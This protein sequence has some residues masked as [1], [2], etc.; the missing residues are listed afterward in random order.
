MNKIKIKPKT[1]KTKKE[2]F[3]SLNNVEHT[4]LV[5]T[6][7]CKLKKDRLVFFEEGSRKSHSSRKNHSSR[8]SQ[9]RRS[10]PADQ[11]KR[12]FF[13]K[14]NEKR[15]ITVQCGTET[16]KCVL[17]AYLTVIIYLTTFPV[18][19]YVKYFI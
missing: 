8:K 15:N 2:F 18:L 3:L 10:T 16:R 1:T 7:N 6:R 19:Q 5:Y 17:C 4:T 11:F 12:M 13:V 14:N 9:A